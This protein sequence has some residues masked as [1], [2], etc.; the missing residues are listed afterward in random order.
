MNASACEVCG[1]VAGGSTDRSRARWCHGCERGLAHVV[2]FGCAMRFDLAAP[3]EYFGPAGPLRDCPDAARV[4][5]ELMP[6]RD[7]NEEL[8]RQALEMSDRS[9]RVV[10]FRNMTPAD[11]IVRILHNK[12]AL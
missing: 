4:M 5:H 11:P 12:M 10:S 7:I 6:E 9:N 2:C 3:A 1:T 8:W